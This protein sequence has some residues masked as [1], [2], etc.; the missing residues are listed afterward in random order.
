VE[1]AEKERRAATEAAEKAAN[2]AALK[3]TLAAGAQ[4]MYLQAAQ[5]QRSGDTDEAGR[6][7]ELIM[8]HFPKGPF[9][10]PLNAQRRRNAKLPRRS[11]NQP[12]LSATLIAMLPAA[13]RAFQWFEVAKRCAGVWVVGL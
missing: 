9:A 1:A 5:K 2:A 7:Y 6:L 12:T 3:K 11:A 8:E 10:V 4:G 13:R